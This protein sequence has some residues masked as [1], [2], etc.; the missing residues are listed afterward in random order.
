[1][2]CRTY[3]D[4]PFGLWALEGSE[5]GLRTVRLVPS[6]SE[7]PEGDGFRILVVFPK[8]GGQWPLQVVASGHK[9]S[10]ARVGVRGRQERAQARADCLSGGS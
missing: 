6:F 10:A 7:L 2:F 1:M 3:L 9:W 5:R 4:T 8:G